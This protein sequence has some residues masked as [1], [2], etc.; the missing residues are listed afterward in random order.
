MPVPL[1]AVP[2]FERRCQMTPGLTGIAQIYARRD[3]PRRQKFRFDHL[4]IRRQS[5]G[6]DLRLIALSF[7]I[8]F[9]GT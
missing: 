8:T 1:E 6:L 9:L 2:G 7:W 5:F 4:Y 3:I